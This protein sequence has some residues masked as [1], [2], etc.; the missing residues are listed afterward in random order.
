MCLH[1]SSRLLHL[2]PIIIV[3]V[4]LRETAT[5][6]LYLS[7][8]SLITNFNRVEQL[9]GL[10]LGFR[11]RVGFRDSFEFRGRVGFRGRVE[12]RG[13]VGFMGRV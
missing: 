12:F 13:R 10:E 9:D 4:N 3:C 2:S 5:L 11:G 8:L 1:M 6:S 7:N